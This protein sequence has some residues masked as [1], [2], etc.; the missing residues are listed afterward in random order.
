VVIVVVVIVVVVMIVVP[1][2]GN[3][4]AGRKQAEAQN[5]Q[6]GE[7]MAEAGRFHGRP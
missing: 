3:E 7:E 5:G 4:A 1:M 2:A 6:E